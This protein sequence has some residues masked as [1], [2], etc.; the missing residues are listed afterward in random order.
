LN[1]HVNVLNYTSK[2][3]NKNKNIFF[4]KELG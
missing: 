1:Q 3:K 4:L 2:N